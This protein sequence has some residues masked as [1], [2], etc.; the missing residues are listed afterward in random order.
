MGW[1][2]LLSL[3]RG[4]SCM[5][6]S[7]TPGPVRNYVLGTTLHSDRRVNPRGSAAPKMV[8]V[9]PTCHTN[10]NA[11]LLACGLNYSAHAGGSCIAAAG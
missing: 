3:A 10:E 7:R 4:G 5:P 11:L 2:G 8:A 6:V 9:S 1:R